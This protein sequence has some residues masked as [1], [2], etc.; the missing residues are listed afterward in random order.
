[1]LTCA[2]LCDHLHDSLRAWCSTDDGRDSAQPGRERL[3]VCAWHD[4][5]LLPQKGHTRIECH[6]YRAPEAAHP[7]GR[8]QHSLNARSGWFLALRHCHVAHSLV[9]S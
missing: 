6:C 9:C 2:G 8:I 5:A 7:L 3:A 1:M 4:V